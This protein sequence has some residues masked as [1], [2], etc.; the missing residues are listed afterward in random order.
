MSRYSQFVRRPRATVTAALL[1]CAA[2]SASAA[3]GKVSKVLPFFLDLKG[4]HALSPSLYD[5]DAYQA[6]LR[7]S[8]ELRSAVRFDVKWSIRNGGFE[9]QKLRLELRGTAEGNQPREKTVEQA[10]DREKTGDWTSIILR[11][12]D[13]KK[14]GEVTAWRVTLWEGDR[15]I[16]EQKS[17]LW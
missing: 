13:Y 14:L 6:Q 3:T 1:L 2:L 5:R 7:K 16:G 11:G 8:P 12:E 15:I 10:L 9:N 4:R 17:F